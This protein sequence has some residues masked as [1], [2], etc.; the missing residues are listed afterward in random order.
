MSPLNM[1]GWNGFQVSRFLNQIVTDTVA[2]SGMNFFYITR[3]LLL[4]VSAFHLTYSAA[5][6]ASC[7]CD[8]V[9]TCRVSY[10]PSQ[11][12]FR[13]PSEV[14]SHLHSQPSTV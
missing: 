1:H 7:N 14:C 4:T 9:R 2:L 10:L 5:I 11:T 13:E 3:T 8:V 12:F 6:E